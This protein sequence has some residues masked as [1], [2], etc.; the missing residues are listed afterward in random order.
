[1]RYLILLKVVQHNSKKSTDTILVEE[2][3]QETQMIKPSMSPARH[4]AQHALSSVAESSHEH[5]LTLSPA[6]IINTNQFQ[7]KN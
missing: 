6:N 2:W 4:T 1:M 3:K 7:D 5:L